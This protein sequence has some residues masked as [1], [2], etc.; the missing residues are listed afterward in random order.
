M[1]KIIEHQEI[2]NACDGTGI[3]SG[4]GEGEG[5]GV[6]CNHCK[7]TGCYSYKHEYEP[8]KARKNRKN[9]IH[10]IQHNPGITCGEGKGYQFK[11]FG[12]MSYLAWKEGKEFLVGSEMRKFTCPAWWYQGVNYELKPNWNECHGCGAFPS[13]TSFKNKYQCWIRWDKEFT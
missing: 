3:Y 8:F 11:D 13:C 5:L 4:I 2:C 9:I 12:G 1:K 7:G 10:V 6:I